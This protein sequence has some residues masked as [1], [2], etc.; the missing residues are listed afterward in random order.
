MILPQNTDRYGLRLRRV[1]L[2]LKLTRMFTQ[3]RQ[4]KPSQTFRRTLVGWL[5]L[6]LLLSQGMRVYFHTHDAL[7]QQADSGAAAFTHLESTA[8]VHADVDEDEAAS[9]AHM[10]LLSLFKHFFDEPVG[11]L[12]LSLLIVLLLPVGR[13]WFSDAGSVRSRSLCRYY[14]TPPLRAP[15]R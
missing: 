1:P 5:I 4:T 11:V 15:P 2:S 14:F 3:T 6:V 9:H 8:G 13:D 7:M 10:P 12:L